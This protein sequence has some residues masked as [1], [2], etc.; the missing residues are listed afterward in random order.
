MAYETVWWA[1]SAFL[2]VWLVAMTGLVALKI[3][4]NEI[5]L[6][7]L[8]SSPNVEDID[9][10]RI[11]LLLVSIFSIAAYGL[12]VATGE[13]IIDSNTESIVMS[14]VPDSLLLILAGGNA[15]YISGKIVR[16][17]QNS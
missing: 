7:G 17:Q 13:R 8:L 5:R 10:E 14:D 16:Q 2:V 4:T 3:L 12:S 9:P 1:L 6:R 15:I 11:G